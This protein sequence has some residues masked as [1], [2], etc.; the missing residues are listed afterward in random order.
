MHN[1]LFNVVWQGY[2]ETL[3]KGF[4]A[5]PRLSAATLVGVSCFRGLWPNPTQSGLTRPRMPRLPACNGGK[6]LSQKGQPDLQGPTA[7]AGLA[8][9][10]P[11]V[12]VPLGWS[13]DQ[14]QLK[15]SGSIRCEAST[16]PGLHHSA[17]LVHT[18][19][20]RKGSGASLDWGGRIPRRPFGKRI[21]TQ[22][23]LLGT[24][25]S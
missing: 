17:F 13:R 15:R 18:I 2:V 12:L 7:S 19:Q 25:V 20:A 14:P 10:M 23:N 22:E 3:Q 9:E 24:L 1:I 4:P 8:E 6:S 11:L 5:R 21:K 16:L